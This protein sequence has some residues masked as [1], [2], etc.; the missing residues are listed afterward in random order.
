MSERIHKVDDPKLK[1]PQHLDYLLD[2]PAAGKEEQENHSWNPEDS[3]L[4]IFIKENE[5]CTL[6]QLPVWRAT[7][8]IRGRIGYSK[9]LH[10]WEIVWPIEQRGYFPMV[11][12]G[13]KEATLF[14]RGYHPLVG[15]TTE[16]WGLDVSECGGSLLYH[17][18]QN[19]CCP[20]GAYPSS[21]EILVIPDKF[22]VVLDMDE[23]TLGF[24]VDSQYLGIAFRGLKGKKVFPMVSSVWCHTEVTMHYINGVEPGPLPLID[25]CRGVIRQQLG[26]DRLQSINSLNLPSRMKSYLF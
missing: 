23:G 8:S 26:K 10:V 11:G 18:F 17:D 1:K 21:Q 16:S 12:V 5:P 7:D 24:M 4:N 14:S 2:I 9:G 15:N 22:R 20:L 25:I 3:S 19:V 6:L 13:T